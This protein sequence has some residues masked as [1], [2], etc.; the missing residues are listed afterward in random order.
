MGDNLRP[1]IIKKK[2]VSGGGGHHGGAWKVA[3]ADFVTAMMAFFMLM[4]LLNA[5][6]EKQR[7]GLAD[8]F[9]PTVPVAS[10]SSG[11]SGALGG[12]TLTADVSRV[13]AGRGGVTD[14]AVHG[15]TDQEQATL[16]AVEAAVLGKG[17]E[18]LLEKDELKHIATRI[19]DEGLVIE[20]FDLPGEPLFRGAEPTQLLTDI[21]V[22]IAPEIHSL[23]NGLALNAFTASAPVVVQRPRLW[24]LSTDRAQTLRSTL[25][26]VGIAQARVSR[27]SGHADRR[28]AT[29]DPLAVRNERVEIVV[30]RAA[31]EWP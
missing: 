3:Y 7:R 24:E 26:T 1:I 6:T 16:E 8:Y 14:S 12:E 5:T 29:R 22:S 25:P 4:W 2:K 20:L 28:P 21:L 23:P 19:T 11:G 10:E 27:V 31:A 13:Q 30:L 9:S 17:G 15:T 18:S